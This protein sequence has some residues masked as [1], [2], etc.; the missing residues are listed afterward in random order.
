MGVGVGVGRGS[1][2]RGSEGL[3]IWLGETHFRYL[4][5]WLSLGTRHPVGDSC[6]PA[7]GPPAAPR[8]RPLHPEPLLISGGRAF[9]LQVQVPVQVP[10]ASG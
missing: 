3:G 4:L 5:E 2:R 10:L 1:L 7:L 9:P 6:W 8:L